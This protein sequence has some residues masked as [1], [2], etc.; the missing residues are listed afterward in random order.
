MKKIPYPLF[1]Y[2]RTVLIST[3]FIFGLSLFI[4]S[5]FKQIKNLKVYET[6][7]LATYSFAIS[8]MHL[9]FILFYLSIF[10]LKIQNNTYTR[11][12]LMFRIQMIPFVI[13]LINFFHNRLLFGDGFTRFDYLVISYISFNFLYIIYLYFESKYKIV[14][15]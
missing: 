4:F 2:L 15:I 8:F 9:I 1:L 10:L 7:S 13:F 3:A 14:K 11:K 12:G 6:G 5:E